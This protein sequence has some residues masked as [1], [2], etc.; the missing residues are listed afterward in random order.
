MGYEYPIPTTTWATR[1]HSNF[2]IDQLQCHDLRGPPTGG[3]TNSFRP[4]CLTMWFA[5][6]LEAVLAYIIVVAPKLSSPNPHAS[7]NN[8]WKRCR[9]ITISSKMLFVLMTMNNYE[10]WH[11][12]YHFGS[13]VKMFCQIQSHIGNIFGCIGLLIPSGIPQLIAKQPKALK[14]GKISMD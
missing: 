12:Y 13:L 4:T 10:N 6:Q 8:L 2:M 9:G 1:E 14:E 3:A 11:T 7:K 5:S